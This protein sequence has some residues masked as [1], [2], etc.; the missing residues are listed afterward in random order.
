MFL[1]S[2]RVLNKLIFIVYV[3]TPLEKYLVIN[4]LIFI[5]FVGTVSVLPLF[6]N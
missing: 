1:E 6:P 4:K 2:I 5:I 3:G